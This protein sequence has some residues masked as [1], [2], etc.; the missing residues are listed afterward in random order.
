MIA[1][2][3]F[4]SLPPKEQAV[5]VQAARRNLAELQEGVKNVRAQLR[6][7]QEDAAKWQHQLA[8]LVDPANAQEDIPDHLVLNSVCRLLG[9]RVEDVLSKRRLARIVTARWAV[10][11]E[12]ARRRWSPCRIAHALKCDHGTVA[13]ALLKGQPYTSYQKPSVETAR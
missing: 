12:L 1:P 13:Y 9:V 8:A 3:D 5:L 4:S 11:H 2:L 6:L 7:L 10:M